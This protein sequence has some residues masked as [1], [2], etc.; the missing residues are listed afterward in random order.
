MH[1]ITFC[2]YTIYVAECRLKTLIL[3]SLAVWF[4]ACLLCF[5]RFT[6]SLARSLKRSGHQCLLKTIDYTMLVIR[7]FALLIYCFHSCFVIFFV[8][9]AFCCLPFNRFIANVP[10]VLYLHFSHLIKMQ[11]EKRTQSITSISTYRLACLINA[12][13]STLLS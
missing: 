2:K 3:W 8:R 6:L 1:R 5:C 13:C 4:G 10:R 9:C 11:K 12:K 7:I